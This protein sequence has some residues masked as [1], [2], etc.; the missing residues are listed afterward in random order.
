[1]DHGLAVMGVHKEVHRTQSV[2]LRQKQ[3]ENVTV[4]DGRLKADAKVCPFAVSAPE[5]GGNEACYPATRLV[6]RLYNSVSDQ[7]RKELSESADLLDLQSKFQGIL[8]S[9]NL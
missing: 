5:A 9:Y 2:S 8:Q 4:Y 1:M 3:G 6:T 7:L